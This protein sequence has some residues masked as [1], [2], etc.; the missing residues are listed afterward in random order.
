MTK[1]TRLRHNEYYSMQ[2]TF[3]KLYAGSKQAINEQIY[4]SIVKMHKK[5]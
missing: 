1:V 5:Y 2:K 4:K 3:D